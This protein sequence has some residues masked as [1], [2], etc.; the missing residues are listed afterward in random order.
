MSWQ[1]FGT[2]VAAAAVGVGAWLLTTKVI[3]DMV[4]KQ[5]VVAAVIEMLITLLFTGLYVYVIDKVF[6]QYFCP[7]QVAV[8][9][10][11]PTQ[12][13]APALA[14]PEASVTAAAA[15]VPATPAPATPAAVPAT[16]AK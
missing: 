16:T 11:P 1:N 2:S 5:P 3:G 15:P 10:E 12:S 9:Q 6:P 4:D 14:A 13:G 7:S 8:P